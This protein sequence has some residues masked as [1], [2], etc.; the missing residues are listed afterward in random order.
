M[1][2]YIFLSKIPFLKKRFPLKVLFVAFVG[3][4]IPLFAIIGYLLITKFP[5]DTAKSIF[6]LTLIFTLLA[7][8]ATLLLLNKLLKPVLIAKNAL[9][10]Y[11]EFSRVPDLPV[12]YTD[13]AGTLLAD[14]QKAIQDLEHYEEERQTILHILSH[15]LQ[16]PV[17]ASLSIIYLLREET[18]IN[19]REELTQLLEDSLSKQLEQLKFYL[20]LLKQ[21]RLDFELDL[22]KKPIAVQTLISEVVDDFKM[23]LAEKQLTIH[24]DGYH[25]SLN[26]P[27]HT[28]QKVLKNVLDN[29]IKHSNEG[30][31]IDICSKLEDGFLEISVR[32]YGTGFE[33]DSS[34]MI[35]KYNSPLQKEGTANEPSSGIGMFLCKNMI[36]R[37]GGDIRAESKG[38]GAGATFTISYLLEE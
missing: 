33:P 29:A 24:M 13:E 15:D 14:V 26:L 17:R 27:R 7:T 28:L 23:H 5:M 1:R 21:Q 2:I 32:D 19:E 20:N 22:D 6:F 25:G 12:Q 37:I 18:D 38:L 8:A 3:I 30:D 36:R 16:S 31:R 9:N 35:F 4:H 11:I 10:D 34:D